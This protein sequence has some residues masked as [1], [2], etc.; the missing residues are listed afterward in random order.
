MVDEN[1]ISL[2]Y[3]SSQRNF[4]S[5][6]SRYRKVLEREKERH[7]IAAMEAELSQHSHK[8]NNCESYL[9]YLRVKARLAQETSTVTP[10]GETGSS[11][12]IT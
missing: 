10:S 4:K 2:R 8:T 7:G 11:E 3:T 9:E 5:G 1:G 12:C 6:L